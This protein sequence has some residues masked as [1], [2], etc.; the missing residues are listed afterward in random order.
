MSDTTA[1]WDYT[2]WKANSDVRNELVRQ[3]G[4]SLLGYSADD[5]GLYFNSVPASG[6]YTLSMLLD[7]L[8]MDLNK[9]A[10]TAAGKTYTVNPVEYD[11]IKNTYVIPS[12]PFRI[13]KDETQY[14]FYGSK[15]VVA[16]DYSVPHLNF[17]TCMDGYVASNSDKADFLAALGEGVLQP[18]GLDSTSVVPE[19][20]DVANQ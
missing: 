4:G 18:T 12:E 2:Y 3:N 8:I 19:A 10:A 20:A 17:I 14:T 5:I 13:V 15:P 9:L 1:S 7:V 11:I 6:D 16:V